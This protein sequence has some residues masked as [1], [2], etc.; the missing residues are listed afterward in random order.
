MSFFV[1]SKKSAIFSLKTTTFAVGKRN[2]LNKTILWQTFTSIRDATTIRRTSPP[3]GMANIF[4]K[5]DTPILR[6]SCTLG[7]GNISIREDTRTPRTSSTPSMASI[8][9]R[10][11]TPTRRISSTPGTANIY[12]KDDIT[13]PQISSTLSMAS[14]CIKD[15]T[16]ILRIFYWL[17]TA[18]CLLSYCWLLYC[19][20]NILFPN[21]LSGWPCYGQ[22]IDYEL[23]NKVNQGCPEVGLVA[24]GTRVSS[25]SL[26][27]HHPIPITPHKFAVHPF[28]FFIIALFMFA[29]DH[30]RGWSPTIARM[31]AT[32]H[33]IAR[34]Q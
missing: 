10:D 7:M 8:Y 21:R 26:L 18:Q 9:T 13:T 25:C 34:Q 6:K 19:K 17:L 5:D 3:H 1:F 15:D 32:I 22:S 24:T 29:G 20:E 31:V 33:A 27:T 12:T 16:L 11:V 2:S 14:I 23:A 28:V 30:S 4:T